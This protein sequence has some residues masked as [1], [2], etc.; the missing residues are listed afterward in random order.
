LTPQLAVAL[1]LASLVMLVASAVL[2]P[3]MLVKI[4]ANYFLLDKP[5][6]MTR[7]R[8]ATPG[9]RWVILLKNLLGGV[10][11]VAGILMLVLPGQGLL[12]ILAGV[13]LLD[14]HGKK[15]LERKLVS[16]PRIL[17]S[18]NWLRRHYGKPELELDE[19][20]CS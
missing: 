14:F 18:V 5:P 1:S 11:V 12:T 2:T 16:R 20:G 3:M 13:F 6:L 10:C 4:P 7:L 17:K 8:G 15:E 9:Y 19:P